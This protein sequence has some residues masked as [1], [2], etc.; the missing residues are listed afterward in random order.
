MKAGIHPNYHPAKV[1]CAG[2]GNEF[3]TR[4]TSN[5]NVLRVEIFEKKMRNC[6]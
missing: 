1:H 6:F 4:T 2:C 3:T 5:E